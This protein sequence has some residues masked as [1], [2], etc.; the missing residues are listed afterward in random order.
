MKRNS[1]PSH[2]SHPFIDDLH[3]YDMTSPSQGEESG[4]EGRG[5]GGV[6]AI[7]IR[8]VEDTE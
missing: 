4:K 6:E 8:R 1:M 3:F 7:S 5:G 2:H